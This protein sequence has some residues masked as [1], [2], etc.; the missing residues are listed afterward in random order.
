M[1]IDAYIRVSQVGGRSG[2]KFISPSLQLERITRWAHLHGA[3][4]ATVHEEL[5]QSGARADRPLLLAAL[6]RVESGETEGIVVARMDR[7]G[8]SLLDS[9]AAIERI[10]K[11]GGTFASVDD[12]LDLTTDTGRLVLRIMLSLAEWELDRIR[13]NWRD[14]R[15]RAVERGIHVASNPPT[16]YKKGSDGRLVPDPLR[17]KWITQAFHRRADGES[18]RDV[19]LWLEAN[20]VPTA[21]GSP[22]WCHTGLLNILRN[23]VYLGEA[24][25]GEFVRPE[26]HPPL[27]DP[28]TFYRAQNPLLPTRGHI[29]RHELL[30]G[31]VRCA[32]CRMSLYTST[33]VKGTTS[34]SCKPDHAAGRCPATAHVKG[35]TLE[36]FVQAEMRRRLSRSA[37]PAAA[38]LKLAKHKHDQAKAALARYRDNHRVEATLGPE[39]FAAGI[40]SRMFV[41]ERAGLELAAVERRERQSRP[42]RRTWDAMTKAERRVVLREE[43]DCIFVARASRVPIA[44]RVFI[45]WRGEAPLDLPRRGRIAQPLRAFDPDSCQGGAARRARPAAFD[46]WTE[47]RLRGELQALLAG[48]VLFPGIEWFREQGQF[49]LYHQVQLQGGP[50]RWAGELNLPLRMAR[51]R[52]AWNDE[53]I[54]AEL[55]ELLQGRGTMPTCTELRRIGRGALWGAMQRHHGVGYWCRQFDV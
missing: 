5:D 25:H 51:A 41:L 14:S 27:I 36:A 18:Y 35:E 26:S 54:E 24:R 38:A 9:L 39:R 43:I 44:D 6:E 46:R 20:H 8:R 31:L 10:D 53:L 2:P 19:A 50:K 21:T 42:D 28:G 45:C 34:Y 47:D 4:I 1:L 33:A 15:R 23:R 48:A 29:R 49:P 22:S 13:R 30:T 12:G 7:F 3:T 52:C 16:G 55:A 11:A 32:S 40:Q 17:A 37:R